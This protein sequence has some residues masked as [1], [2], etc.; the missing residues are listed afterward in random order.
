MSVALRFCD[1]SGRFLLRSVLVCCALL[2]EMRKISLAVLCGPFVSIGAVVHPR[3]YPAG[4]VSR[5]S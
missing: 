3:R 2:W 4:S 5:S 1:A